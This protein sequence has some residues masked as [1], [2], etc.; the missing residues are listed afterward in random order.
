[1]DPADDK[2]APSA[3]SGDAELIVLGD[4]YMLDIKD[5]KGIKIVNSRI[6]KGLTAFH[7]NKESGCILGWS[8]S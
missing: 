7:V 3:A 8:Y 6:R 5:F 1:M 2:F 4:K